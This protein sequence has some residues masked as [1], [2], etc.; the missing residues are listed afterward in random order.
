M[1]LTENALE[2][3]M[4]GGLKTIVLYKSNWNV[5]ECSLHYLNKMSSMPLHN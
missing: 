5:A 2:I 1:K 3:L 4:G